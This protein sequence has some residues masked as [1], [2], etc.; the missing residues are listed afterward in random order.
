[1]TVINL[2]SLPRQ[3]FVSAETDST[4]SEQNVAHGM[5]TVPAV[6]L[7]S[8]TEF[9]AAEACDI[10]EGTHD[11]V[12]IKLTITNGRKFKVFAIGSAPGHAV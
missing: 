9:G 2:S 6:V 5:R 10:A 12:N 7:V 4:G 11:G 3:V 1:M 8:L